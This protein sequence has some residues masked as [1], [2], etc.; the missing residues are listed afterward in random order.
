MKDVEVLSLGSMADDDNHKYSSGKLLE[1]PILEGSFLE[2]GDTV[3][4][5]EVNTDDD[6]TSTKRR[7]EIPSP[8]TGRLVK[9]HFQTGQ[10]INVGDT[11]VTIDTDALGSTSTSADASATTTTTPDVD[12]KTSAAVQSFVQHIQSDPQG[13]LSDEYIQELLA[14]SDVE[15]LRSLAALLID[16]F[17][18]LRVKAL[19]FLERV[20]DLQRTTNAEGQE[21]ATTHTDL[22]ILLYQLGDLEAA[23]TQ[24]EAALDLRT[25]ALGDSHPELSATLIHIGAIKNQKQDLD[26]CFEAFERALQIQKEHLGADHVLVAASLNNLGAILYHKGDFQQAIPYY[27]QALDIYKAQEDGE[28]SPDTAGSYNNLAVAIK[29]TGDY[30]LAVDYARRALTIR[31]KAL[32]DDHLTTATSHYCLGQIYIETQNHQAATEQFQAALI[33]QSAKLGP[34]H[35]TTAGTHNNIGATHY[36][37]GAFDKALEEYQLGLEAFQATL[38]LD[39]PQVADCWNNV[40]MAQTR[41]GDYTTALTSHQNAERILKEKFGEKH[42]TLATTLGSIGTVYK[43][44]R[45]YDQALEYYKKSHQMLEEAVGADHDMVGSSYNNMGQVLALQGNLEEA[46]T[47]YK[48]ALSVFQKVLSKDHVFTG[49][50]HYNIGLVQQQQGNKT[51][52]ALASYRQAYNIWDTALGEEHPQ[53]KLAEE[54]I[55]ALMNKEKSTNGDS[56]P[57]NGNATPGAPPGKRS[58]STG[59]TA[60][61][62]RSFSSSAAAA[63]SINTSGMYSNSSASFKAGLPPPH[64]FPTV[65]QLIQ[66]VHRASKYNQGN[67]RNILSSRKVRRDHFWDVDFC[68]ATT[69][70]YEHYLTELA[71]DPN[72]LSQDEKAALLAD[73]VVDRAFGILLKCKLKPPKLS[74]KVRD[75]ERAL[76]TIGDIPLTATLSLRLVEVNGKAGN[77]GRV[78]KLL[79]YRSSQLYKPR[80]DEFAHAVTAVEVA[81]WPL[82]HNRN[83]FMSDADQPLMDNPTRWLDAIL[84][85]MQA[86]Q[87]PLSQ[88]LAA[89]MLDTFASRGRTGKAM[90]YFYSV[91]RTP[92]YSSGKDEEE[93]DQELAAATNDDEADKE[94]DAAMQSAYSKLPGSQARPYKVR[95]KLKAPPPYYKIPT[96]V[97]GKLLAVAPKKSESGKKTKESSNPLPSKYDGVLKI[98]RETEP[99]WSLPL[100]AAFSFADSL[101]HGACGHDPIELDLVCYNILIKTCVYRGALWRAM[102]VLDAVMPSAGVTPDTR[103]YDSLLSGLARVGDVTLMRSRYQE[104]ISQGIEPSPFTVK[105]VVD[106]L[107]NLGDVSG[108]ITV[109]QDF[110]NQHNILPPIATQLK[111]MEFALGLDMIYEAKRHMYFIQQIWK[112][113]PHYKYES[114][115]F[116]YYMKTYQRDR[117]IS[118]DS[119]QHLFAYFGERLEESDFF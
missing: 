4:V 99:D 111:V 30:T 100:T 118:K 65:D 69:N 50:I 105:H 60:A 33:I 119:L 39:A 74:S 37:Q 76:G 35:P 86:R 81:G 83:I 1:S 59:V 71:N 87:F 53:T 55:S 13:Q 45:E 5:I 16:K 32:G 114:K 78:M 82:R 7:F 58:F 23:L 108:A 106:G 101:A 44:L 63:A 98:D 75:W 85:N 27:Q 70:A 97:K 61:G 21:Q 20:L 29:H 14:A 102:N 12:D 25:T 36:E 22:G 9:I 52:E 88:L 17:P 18:Q 107:L 73:G 115:A 89:M 8:S 110:F 6:S 92:V 116:V 54:S 56:S 48:A 117:R 64:G 31:T 91:H 43:N 96:D 66:D 95:M 93:Y 104:M 113:E 47:V 40:G 46:L 41:L 19:P 90:H 112:W 3:G 79:D 67:T 51:E 28:E 84:L 2:A 38:G 26:G 77:I 94:Y 68:V 15:T 57:S 10:E 72:K 49:S 62:R 11:L 42:P 109:I 80:H 24:L 103:S 34:Q